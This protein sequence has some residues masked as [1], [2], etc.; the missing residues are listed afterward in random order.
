MTTTQDPLDR[1]GHARQVL[2]PLLQDPTRQET[3][4]R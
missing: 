4:Q 2:D 3:V 1:D